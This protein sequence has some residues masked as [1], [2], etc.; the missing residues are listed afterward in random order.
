VRTPLTS[1]HLVVQ[2]LERGVREGR[3]SISPQ[4]LTLAV[5]QSQRLTV[6]VTQLLDVVHIQSGQLALAVEEFDLVADTRQLLERMQ[7]QIEQAGSPV[8]LHA[9]E[10]LVGRWDRSRIDQLLTNLLSNALS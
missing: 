10:T 7:V 8:T 9:E 3:P 5:R 1:L 4:M 2:S 6:L